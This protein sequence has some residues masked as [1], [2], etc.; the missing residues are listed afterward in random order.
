LNIAELTPIDLHFVVTRIPKDV[1]DLI[2]S[3][4]LVLAGGFIRAVIAGEKPND[5]DLFGKTEDAI[6]QAALDFALKRS[7]KAHITKNAI[8]VATNGRMTVQFITRWCYERA[9]DLIKSFDY[10]VAQAAIGHSVT[11][12]F[13]G[14]QGKAWYGLCSEEFYP[15]LAAR[16]LTY[17]YPVR[18]EDAGG[19]MMRLRKFLA[20]GYNIQAPSMAGVI[21]RLMRGIDL[22]KLDGM[23]GN[24]KDVAK[25]ITNLLREVDPLIIIDG[26]PIDEH[27]P[28]D[29]ADPS[30]VP[31]G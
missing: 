30:E 7:T 13:D 20:R 17:T 9:E 8:T 19:S 21:A 23:L 11:Y 10:T 24:E 29:N 18:N 3:H 31:I 6:K 1:R 5:I 27:E 14:T 28:I 12:H 15:D 22:K 16:R 26:I 4:N 2:Q 25:A